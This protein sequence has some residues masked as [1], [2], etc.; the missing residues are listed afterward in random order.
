MG[1]GTK[2]ELKFTFLNDKEGNS[3]KQ[4][5]ETPGNHLS[6]VSISNSFW[7]SMRYLMRYLDNNWRIGNI[8]SGCYISNQRESVYV[9]MCVCVCVY[10]CMFVCMCICVCVCVCVCAQSCWTLCYPMGGR[11]QVLLSMEFSRQGYWSGYHFLPQEIF[12][13][14]G[15]N[16]LLLSLFHWKQILYQWATWEALSNQRMKTI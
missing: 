9:C 8:S 12:L 15:S 7:F 3:V 10:V 1:V 11:S 13:T 5:S 16:L 4:P 2:Q 6:E 14:Q